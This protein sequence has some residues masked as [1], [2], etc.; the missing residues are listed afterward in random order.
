MV[1][2]IVDAYVRHCGSLQ[3]ESQYTCNRFV[4]KHQGRS[5]A[6]VRHVYTIAFL[7][8]VAV[9]AR[10]ILVRKCFTCGEE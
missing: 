6:K 7:I 10:E 3:N 5:F 8:F 2:N 4:Y 1:Y 9:L